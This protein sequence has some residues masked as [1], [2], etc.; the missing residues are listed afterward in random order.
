M[1]IIPKPENKRRTDSLSS[2]PRASSEEASRRN[3]FSNRE[4]G[5]TH[6]D[7][8]AYI[9]LC[10]NGDIEIMAAPGVGIIISALNKSI[11]LHADDIK[12][13]SK[14]NGLNWNENY[15][16][17]NSDSFEEPALQKNS[18]EFYN[19]A[20]NGIELL[21]EEI[22]SLNTTTITDEDSDVQSLLVGLDEQS[23]KYFVQLA[24]E[25]SF[26]HVSYAINLHKNFGYSLS[27]A[28]NKA[29]IDRGP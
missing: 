23:V 19:S 25:Y 1:P 16:N 20:F 24:K 11:T 26:E 22:R 14:P 12:I 2:Y 10:D 9:K 28:H 3:S 29:L 15:F 18:P 8:S 4:V 7:T 21:L 5:I 17:P 6:P 13:Y 27:Q